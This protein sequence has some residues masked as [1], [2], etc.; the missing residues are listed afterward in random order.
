M[1]TAARL[2]PTNTVKGENLRPHQRLCVLAGVDVIG[3][4]RHRTAVCQ[5]F[6]QLLGQ[7]GFSSANRSADTNAQWAMR[8]GHVR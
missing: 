6:A 7:S 8:R 1:R 2:Y 3:D 4:H 5:L